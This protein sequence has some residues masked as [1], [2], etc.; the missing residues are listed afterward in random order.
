MKS[1]LMKL[2]E[3]TKTWLSPKHQFYNESIEF[4]EN[5]AAAILLQTQLSQEITPM[6]NFELLRL[7]TFGLHLGREEVKQVISYARNRERILENILQMLDTEKKQT[8]FFAGF[9]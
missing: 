1:T 2:K 8:V 3:K 7:F 5:Y 9:I 4:R 6:D